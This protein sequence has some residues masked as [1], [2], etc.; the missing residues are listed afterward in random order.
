MYM[1]FVIM[2]EAESKIEAARRAKQEADGV[3]QRIQEAA[4]R[5]ISM[6]ESSGVYYAPDS[7]IRRCSKDLTTVR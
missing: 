4:R 2:K 6:F 1:V 5:P 3:Q 7:A